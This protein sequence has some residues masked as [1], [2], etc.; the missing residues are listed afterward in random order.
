MNAGGYPALGG[1]GRAN[2][3]DESFQML[4]SSWRLKDTLCLDRAEPAGDAA[5]A[6]EN[7]FRLVSAMRRQFGLFVAFCLVGIAVGTLY[8]MT[9]TP[10][11]TASATLIL[12]NRQVRAVRDV[13][14]LSDPVA[15]DA[16]EVVESQV[17]VLRSEQVGLA[18]VR[19]LHLSPE[20]PVF[21]KPTWI[22]E[23]W[24]SFMEKLKTA[25]MDMLKTAIGPR[26]NGSGQDLQD[27]S[28]IQ[29]LKLLKLLNDNL[30]ISRVGHTFV[31]RVDYASPNRS[32]AADVAN[33]YA[34]A[35]LLEQ[36]SAS[37]EATRRARAWLEKRTEE[38]RQSS[39]DADL[40][41]QKFKADNNL[42]ATKGALVSEQ[43]LNEMTSQL[44]TQRSATAEA[45]AR[46]VRIKDIIDSH[47][48]ESAVTEA[49]AN[50][51]ITEV[52]T[53]Y[54]EA[55]KRMLDL[56]RKLGPAH[57]TV[58]D[59]K[60]TMADLK[61]QLFQELGRVAET[62]R[63][64]YEIAVAREKVLTGNLAR[65]QAVA[66]AA[67][68][69]QV[70]LR[71]LEQKAES[72]KTLYQTFLQRYQET[73][74]Q[75]SFPLADVH[76]VSAATPPLAP[77]HPRTILVLAVSIA[78]GMFTGAGVAVL[79]ER[80]DNVFR[81]LEQVR[82]ELG[83]DALG[84]LPKI[85]LAS[86][87]ENDSDAGRSI[88]RYAIDNRFSAFAETLR[89]AKMAA[90]LA[91]GE[92]TSKIIGLVS[93]L[94]DEGKSTVAK[95]FAS[96]LASQG[97]SVLLIDADTR[98]PSLT[99][100][101]G[102]ERKPSRRHTSSAASPLAELITNEPET[103]LKILPCVYAKDDPRVADGLSAAMLHSLLQSSDQSFEYIIIDL[104]PIGPV[105]SARAIA[106]TI[107]AFIFVVEW[108]LT[109]RC[110][111]RAALAKETL[112]REKLLGV[113]LNKVAMQKLRIYEHFGS[114]GYYSQKYETYY[115]R[116]ETV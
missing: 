39:V 55:S 50:A 94:P 70:Q 21:A 49:L 67:N 61:A 86:L 34:N 11:Y 93:L 28:A 105:V 32:R 29:E 9:A 17:E 25:I 56:E 101:I 60:D 116:R 2:F 76:I 58:T 47:Q 87:A 83:V 36:L 109:S 5:R 20:D 10:L 44:V 98:N 43:Q 92:R 108:G 111:V 52:R 22:D 62:Y 15:L 7:F 35:Y 54:L 8:V 103:G 99:R 113:I 90:D 72:S 79:R 12:D 110:A 6:A 69:A 45:K 31:L 30:R 107:D 4:Q 112:I 74:Q 64:D 114:Y 3:V 77:S 88:M 23:L 75:E 73:A 27:N 85:S 102:R 82:D 78:L 19:N 41:A 16:P 26:V 97:A 66:V 59:L 53:K 40:A 42:L 100:A 48:S 38:L 13:S 106:S 33:A 14:S 51:V 81:T 24:A 104:P 115:K 80:A 1:K 91:L 46:Y 57:K 37:V 84:Q 71:Q 68:N 95:N 65:Q 63:N 96:L 18:V 89:S